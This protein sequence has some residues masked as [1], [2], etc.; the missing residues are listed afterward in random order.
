MR[1]E[2][3]KHQHEKFTSTILLRADTTSQSPQKNSGLIGCVFP[4]LHWV[5]APIKTKMPRV[6]SAGHMEAFAMALRVVFL[7]HTI[8]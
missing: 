7:H 2:A 6:P 3:H 4:L 8:A 1:D 5:A